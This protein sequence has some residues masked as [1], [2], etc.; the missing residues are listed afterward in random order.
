[1]MT[2]SVAETVAGIRIPDSALAKEAT[3]SWIEI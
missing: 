3:A 1:M 2:V